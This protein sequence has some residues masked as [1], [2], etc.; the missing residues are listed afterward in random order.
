MHSLPW[1]RIL[2]P[3][4]HTDCGRDVG[5]GNSKAQNYAPLSEAV[6]RRWSIIIGM[7]NKVKKF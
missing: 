1:N 4:R 5:S 6:L 3:D 7:A 2:L